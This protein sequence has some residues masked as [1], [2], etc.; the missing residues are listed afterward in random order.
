MGLVS[1]DLDVDA[2]LHRIIE[3]CPHSAGADVELAC[4][5]RR[6]HARSGVE[7]LEFGFN[8][9]GF[10]V[11]GLSRNVEGD[12]AARIDDADGDSVEGVGQRRHGGEQKPGQNRQCGSFH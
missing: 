2:A 11:A 1:D 3:P 12:V 9:L 8:A 6:D 10:K 5:E 7:G 4:S